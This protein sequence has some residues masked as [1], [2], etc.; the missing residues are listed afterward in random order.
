MPRIATAITTNEQIARRRRNLLTL[1]IAGTIATIALGHR[2]PPTNTLNDARVKVAQ[3]D[4]M[5]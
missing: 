2:N 3:L 4:T 1:A 5:P